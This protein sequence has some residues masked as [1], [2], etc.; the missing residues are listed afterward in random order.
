M[1]TINRLDKS[2]VLDNILK[3]TSFKKV[4]KIASEKD[5][6]I[7]IIRSAMAECGKYNDAM[8]DKWYDRLIKFSEE[9]LKNIIKEPQ[10]YGLKCRIIMTESVK[11][12]LT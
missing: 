7:S 11:K 8:M 2:S 4:I 6:L 10:K 1:L 5:Q 12:I 3:E 9:K